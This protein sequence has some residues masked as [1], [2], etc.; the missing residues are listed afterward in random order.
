MVGTTGSLKQELQEYPVAKKKIIGNILFQLFYIYLKTRMVISTYRNSNCRLIKMQDKLKWNA[1]G[2]VKKTKL[3]KNYIEREKQEKESLP[4]HQKERTAPLSGYLR[5][6]NHMLEQMEKIEKII[7]LKLEKLFHLKFQ[8]P[9]MIMLALTRPSIRTIFENLNAHFKD[10]PNRPLSE[11]ELMELASSGD[12]AVV[13]A[14]I[15]DAALDLAIVQTLWDSSLSKTGELTEKRKKLASNE[16]LAI[17]CD[18]WGLYSSRLHRLQIIPDEK[19]KKETVEHVKG[20]LVESIFGVVYLEFKL[21][22]LLRIV[23]LIQ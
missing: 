15:G 5:E 22:E 16:N 3:L 9:E 1:V 6:L 20:T 10:D 21:K 17:Y 8:T 2:L 14:L 23:P 18:E 4:A 7:I 19:M 11:E 12:A 13:L